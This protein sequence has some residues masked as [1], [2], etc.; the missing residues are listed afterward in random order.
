MR[1]PKICKLWQPNRLTQSRRRRPVHGQ[2]SHPAIACGFGLNDIFERL[3]LQAVS[4]RCPANSSWSASSLH[5]NRI[6]G[7]GLHR[8][9]RTGFSLMEVILSI[10]VL[11]ASSVALAQLASLGRRHADRAE[12]LTTAQTLCQNKLNE[13]VAGLAPLVS[14]NDVPLGEA[15]GWVYS[16]VVEP[17]R[18]NDLV[19]VQVSVAEMPISGADT[20]SSDAATTGPSQPRFSLVR[21]MRTTDAT[22]SEYDPAFGT[23]GVTPFAGIAP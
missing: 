21:W 17:A 3:R 22:S 10:A 4:S 8:R 23:D 18:W 9:H 2:P 12:S 16:V 6:H 20:R 5:F 13:I 19:S 11:F 7:K 1:H 15:P 14:A